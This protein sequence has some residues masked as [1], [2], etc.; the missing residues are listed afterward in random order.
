MTVHG[1]DRHPGG[2]PIFNRGESPMSSYSLD[3]VKKLAFSQ[4]IEL[5]KNSH[6]NNLNEYEELL[7]NY[8][9]HRLKEIDK[10]HGETP[11]RD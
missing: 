4:E 8:M 6:P 10:E 3:M 9:E 5:I 1:W 7:V 11:V 2:R